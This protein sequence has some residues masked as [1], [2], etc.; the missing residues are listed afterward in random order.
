V[1]PG[2]EQDPYAVL[3]VPRTASEQEIRAAY[4][5]LGARYHPDR[6]QGNPLEDLASAK[7]RELNR[8]YAILSNPARRAAFDAGAGS[9]PFGAGVGSA[10]R[11]GLGGNGRSK[12]LL[13]WLIALPFLL[14]MGPPIVR[15]VVVVL[16]EL[17]E[18]LAALRGTPFGAAF[19]LV[20]LLV[21]GIVLVRQRRAK[22]SAEA[23]RNE[24]S[25]NHSTK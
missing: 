1:I 6:H 11:G 24:P 3:G 22:A 16:R 4:R 25:E 19:V 8:A 18:A 20:A 9:G 15:G 17:F 23:K 14:R 5:A 10:S 7:M 21:L 2:P 12:K 13:T